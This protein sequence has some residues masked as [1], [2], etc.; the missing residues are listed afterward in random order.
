MQKGKQEPTNAITTTTTS[1]ARLSA[2]DGPAEDAG[3]VTLGRACTPKG[4][5]GSPQAFEL[6]RLYR[7]LLDHGNRLKVLTMHSSRE[8][9]RANGP[10]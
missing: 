5:V 9:L 7:C 4:P 2:R 3:D 6:V 10:A 1:L 8:R